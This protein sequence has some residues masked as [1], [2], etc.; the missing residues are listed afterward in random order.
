MLIEGR[1]EN[2]LLILA[3]ARTTRKTCNLV[4]NYSRVSPFAGV[5][6]R[7]LI[8]D[9]MMGN[10]GKTIP[11]FRLRLQRESINLAARPSRVQLLRLK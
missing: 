4:T 2:G 3:R 1:R 6:A 5:R 8:A 7:F 9:P 10:R 11:F